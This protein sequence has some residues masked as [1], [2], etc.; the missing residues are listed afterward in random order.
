[1]SAVDRKGER[2]WGRKAERQRAAEA[3][4]Q[5]CL[6]LVPKWARNAAR[7]RWGLPLATRP[8]SWPA[9]H[10][11]ESFQAW[12]ALHPVSEIQVVDLAELAQ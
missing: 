5:H 4:R 9:I 3:L 1:M 7:V 11:E 6:G 2:E 8:R 12:L 10:R